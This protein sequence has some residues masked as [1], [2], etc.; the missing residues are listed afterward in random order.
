MEE[1]DW[2]N[3][4]FQYN[5]EIKTYYR[6]NISDI[7]VPTKNNTLTSNA[8]I[9]TQKQIKT[10]KM[11]DQL[12]SLDKQFQ[13]SSYLDNQLKEID[14]R[15]EVDKNPDVVLVFTKVQSK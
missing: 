10:T 2:K 13:T 4:R 9:L 15:N 14:H 11:E 8:T 1:T 3:F 5:N 6:I 7:F 12:A